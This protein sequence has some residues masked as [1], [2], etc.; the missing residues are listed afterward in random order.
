MRGQLSTTQRSLGHLASQYWALTKP[1]VTQLAIFCAVIGMF[2]A[3]P[4]LPSARVGSHGHAGH[5]AACRRGV[6]RQLADR[7]THRREDGAHTDATI[8]AWRPDSGAGA[9]V[10][11]RHRRRRHVGAAHAG[12]SADDVAHLRDVRRLCGRLHRAAQA[13]HAAE[14][15][16]RRHERRNASGARLGG[17]DQQCAA[18]SVAAR[19]DHLRVDAAALLGA[20]AVPHR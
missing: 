12:Q 9:G 2:L 16:H 5:L 17:G 18:G 15:R 7:A 19:A 13:V 20:G 8:A 10:F 11:R 14:H 3:V 6:R 4:G 1:R